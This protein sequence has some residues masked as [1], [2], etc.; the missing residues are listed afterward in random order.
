MKGF[1]VRTGQVILTRVDLFPEAYTSKLQQLQDG[2]E[3]MLFELVKSVVEQELLG[4]APLSELF[5]SFDPEPL[6]S[7]SIAQVHKA[8]LL[9]GRVVPVK[10]Q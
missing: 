3:P 2:I 6:G 9:D 4:G 8:S 7:A 10:L 1:Y 5:Q